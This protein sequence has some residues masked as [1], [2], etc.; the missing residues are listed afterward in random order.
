M[1]TPPSFKKDAIPSTRGWHDPKTGELLT[2]RPM[3]QADVDEYNGVVIHPMS[4]EELVIDQTIIDEPIVEDVEEEVQFLTE[5]D[6]TVGELNLEILS[7]RELK[8]MCDEHGIS[9][10]WTTR[11]STLIERLKEVL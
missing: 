3:S 6:P 5:A 8:D 2:A 9:Y 7:S 11:K 4:E 1:L 10:G